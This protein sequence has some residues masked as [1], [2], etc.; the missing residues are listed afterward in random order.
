MYILTNTISGISTGGSV[1]ISQYLGAKREKDLNDTI[2][3]LFT[4]FIYSAFAF[5][6]LLLCSNNLII[7]LLELQPEA[8]LPMK[9]YLIVCEI[10]TLFIFLYNCISAVLQAMGDSKHPLLF[11]GIACVV[12]IAL[13][14][15]LVAVYDMGAFGAAIATVIAQLLSV[16]L[17][18]LFLRKQNFAFKFTIKDFRIEMT[19]CRRILRLG[20][21]YAIQRIFVSI[22]FLAISGLSNPYGLA[23]GA[24][25]GVVN[26]INNFVTL[27]YTAIQVAISAMTGQNMG[28][29]QEKRAIKSLWTGVSICLVFGLFMFT[30]AHL[31]P[32]LMLGVFS[33]D[34]EM[35]AVGADFLK[36][37]SFEYIFMAFTWTVHGFMSACGHTLIPSIDGLL[38]SVVFRIPLALLFSRALGMGFTGIAFGSSMAV[39][40]ALIPGMIF[41]FSGVWRK[42]VIYR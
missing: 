1:L 14:L 27:P 30:L 39:I 25:A 17:S 3:T 33:K 11:V 31:C 41:Y 10:G 6:V 32:E 13:D 35:L 34:P 24:A 36:A 40:G 8:V 12:N 21:P 2:S 22:S 38:A 26:K 4:M 16:I 23:A 9:Q 42:D 28:A 29:G 7:R 15:L 19:Q 5:T 37:Y 20:L 18:V